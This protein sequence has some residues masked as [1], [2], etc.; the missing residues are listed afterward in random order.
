MCFRFLLLFFLMMIWI[1]EII[2]KS[3]L[4][5]MVCALVDSVCVVCD[6]NSVCV[7]VSGGL[8]GGGISA[9]GTDLDNGW[10]AGS[11]SFTQTVK[12]SSF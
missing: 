1:D 12:H 11:Q 5:N 10:L 9:T 2:K 6:S 7:C 3:Y 8:G 4:R